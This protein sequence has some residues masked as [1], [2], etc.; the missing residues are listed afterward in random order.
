MSVTDDK[1]ITIKIILSLLSIIIITCAISLVFK[2]NKQ[3]G[4]NVDG[5]TDDI[6]NKWNN[7]KHHMERF[8]IVINEDFDKIFTSIGN[9][10]TNGFKFFGDNIDIL[11]NYF[12]CGMTK[13]ENFGEC[14][15]F[16]VIDIICDLIYTFFYIIFAIIGQTW[17]LDRTI[18]FM[19]QLDCTIYNAMGFH[20]FQ[21]PQTVLDHCYLCPKIVNSDNKYMGFVQPPPP[22]TPELENPFDELANAFSL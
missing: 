20:I 22:D 16:Y 1:N 5:I 13:I 12:E 9:N 14:F 19:K 11:G 7:F 2:D 4:F 18:E 6:K 10:F 3:E 17:I 21:Y 15:I 8:G